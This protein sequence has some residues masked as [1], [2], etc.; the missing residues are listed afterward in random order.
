V[1]VRIF[2]KLPLGIPLRP[3]YLREFIPDMILRCEQHGY[4]FVDQLTSALIER[5]VLLIHWQAREIEAG[6][7]QHRCCRVIDSLHS[8]PSFAQYAPLHFGS[9]SFV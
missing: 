4:R 2:G 5:E 7:L 8:S 1:C 3:L 6:V 9:A